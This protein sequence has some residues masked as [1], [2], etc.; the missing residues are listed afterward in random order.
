MNVIAHQEKEKSEET[1]GGKR[2]G[3]EKTG[4]RI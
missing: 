3:K 4:D 2:A 1:K